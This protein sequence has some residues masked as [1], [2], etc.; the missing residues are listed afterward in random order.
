[1][2]KRIN[3]FLLFLN[4]VLASETLF[5]QDVLIA[6]NRKDS[7]SCKVTNI[8]PRRVHYLVWDGSQTVAKS[9]DRAYLSSIRFQNGKLFSFPPK[10]HKESS[11]ST[12]PMQRSWVISS[13]LVPIFFEQL[14]LRV[15]KTIYPRFSAKLLCNVMGVGSQTGDIDHVSGLEAAVGLKYTFQRKRATKYH[16]HLLN[17]WFA[18]AEYF[19]S[20]FVVEEKWWD[21][22]YPA[23]GDPFN[24]IKRQVW[25]KAFLFSI[26]R[27]WI[28]YDRIAL[29]FTYGLGTGR[30]DHKDIE[31]TGPQKREPRLEDIFQQIGFFG[32]GNNEWGHADQFSI[33]IGVLIGKKKQ[34]ANKRFFL[35]PRESTKV[36]PLSNQ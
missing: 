13:E 22:S 21:D 33:A 1:M 32:G 20:S 15:E 19:Q 17:G 16:P 26:G 2:I 30:K 34:V 18:Q 28:F 25:G 14:K 35:F 8:T 23:P 5:S 24:T 12:Y 10:S 6:D 27:Q 3:Q 7:L 31:R 29:S 36:H 11:L 9:I 4:L